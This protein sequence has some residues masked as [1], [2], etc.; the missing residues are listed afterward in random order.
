MAI[1]RQY[2]D[3]I[4]G[5]VHATKQSTTKEFDTFDDDGSGASFG[6]YMPVLME[7]PS[8]PLA[9]LEHIGDE[10]IKSLAINIMLRWPLRQLETPVKK[11]VLSRINVALI[12]A[13][14]SLVPDVD[15]ELNS[16]DEVDVSICIGDYSVYPMLQTEFVAEKLLEVV[17]ECVLKCDYC[18]FIVSAEDKACPG[19]RRKRVGYS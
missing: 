14:D 6:L 3:P 2:V 1:I 10:D 12:K 7:N 15:Y 8:K 13:L 5:T 17:L 4:T 18:G 16:G 19:C 11:S 9:V